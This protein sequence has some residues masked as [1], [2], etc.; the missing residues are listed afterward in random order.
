[1]KKVICDNVNK[2]PTKLTHTAAQKQAKET[3]IQT[4]FKPIQN[5]QKILKLPTG[6][7]TDAS[8]RYVIFFK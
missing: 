6:S 8:W 7:Y 3:N 5:W 4:F 1:M 2:V